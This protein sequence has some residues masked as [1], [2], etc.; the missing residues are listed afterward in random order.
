MPHEPFSTETIGSTQWRRS[1]KGLSSCNTLKVTGAK[2]RSFSFTN[3]VIFGG[4]A[5]CIIDAL[6]L[7]SKPCH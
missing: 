1:L 2:D 5:K 3:L 6:E 4:Q 7:Y